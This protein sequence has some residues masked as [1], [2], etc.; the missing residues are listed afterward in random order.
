[1][2]Y[3]KATIFYNFPGINKFML[4]YNINASRKESASFLNIVL[5]K[6]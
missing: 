5:M 2:L 4:L 6:G 1:M 3:F